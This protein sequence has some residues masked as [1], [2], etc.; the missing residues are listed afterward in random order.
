MAKKKVNK[1]ANKNTDIGK[2]MDKFDKYMDLSDEDFQD[3]LSKMSPRERSAFKSYCLVG[4]LKSMVEVVDG[5]DIEKAIA[6]SAATSL[7]SNQ[8]MDVLVVFLATQVTTAKQV[9]DIIKNIS[10]YKVNQDI[11]S[12]AGVGKYWFNHF[13]GNSNAEAYKS[14]GD[15]EFTHLG[16]TLC[17]DGMATLTPYGVL[18]NVWEEKPQ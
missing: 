2:M 7:K 9:V 3:R 10:S 1:K 8:V 4:I 18:W 16:L 11:T 5:T 13:V 15:T 12:F 14:W 6:L 17:A